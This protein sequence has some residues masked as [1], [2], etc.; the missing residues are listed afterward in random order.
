VGIDSRAVDAGTQ[1]SYGDTLHELA[2]YVRDPKRLPQAQELVM[3]VVGASR[4]LAQKLL[5]QTPCVLLGRLSEKTARCIAERFR[6]IEV[7]V[8][9]ARQDRATYDVFVAGLPAAERYRLESGLEAQGLQV[10]RDRDQPLLCTGLS[11]AQA[12]VIWERGRHAPGQLVVLCR[13]FQRFDVRLV[14]APDTEAGTEVLKDYLVSQVGM[15]RAVADKVPRRTPLV[16]FQSIP[17]S[18]MQ[19]RLQELAALGAEASAQL[20]AFV[21]FSLRLGAIGDV[22]ASAAVL[23]QLCGLSPDEARRALR[24]RVELQ[25]RLTQTQARWAQWELKQAGTECTIKML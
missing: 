25:E 19:A 13:D 24:P 6:A 9:I 1:V 5:C 10:N 22:G 2:I 7:E 16:I 8:E 18:Q 4:S 3:Q 17:F 20:L 21:R 15:P 23:E 14:T 12:D 11:K